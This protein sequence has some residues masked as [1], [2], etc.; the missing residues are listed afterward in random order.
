MILIQHWNTRASSDPSLLVLESLPI[1]ILSTILLP[2]I[3]LARVNHEGEV[4][5]RIKAGG[6]VVQ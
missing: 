4:A 2:D 5:L 6:V 3:V 1:L